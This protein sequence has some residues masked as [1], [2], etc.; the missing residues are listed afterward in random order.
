MEFEFQK[1]TQPC[2]QKIK[3]EVRN[4]EE[5]QE[6]RIPE[7]MPDVGTVLGAW[8][9]ALLRGKQWHSGEMQVTAGVMAWVMYTPE[10]GG[11]PQMLETWI[12]MQLRWDLPDTDRDGQIL[13][14]SV[15]RNVDARSV[16]ARKILVRAGLGVLAEAVVPGELPVYQPTDIPEDVQ[17]LTTRYPLELAAE[18]G[19]KPFSLEEILSLP[20]GSP[21]MEKPVYYCLQPRIG[22]TKVLAGKV[23]FRG[24]AQLHLLYMGQ[25]GGLYSVD[26]E[27]PFSQYGE[28][29]QDYDPDATAQVRCE[30][31]GLELSSGEEGQWNLKAGLTGQYM[32]YHCP[33]I[34]VVEDGYSLTREAIPNYTEMPVT[35]VLDRSGQTI[36]VQQTV[37]TDARRVIDLSMMADHGTV[38]NHDGSVEITVPGVC[39]MLYE[40]DQGQLRSMTAGWEEN[41]DLP[42]DTQSKVYPYI[43]LCGMPQAVVGADSVTLRG[44]LQIDAVTTSGGGM[45]MVSGL[46][47]GQE[48]VPDPDRPSLLLCRCGSRSLW[49]LAKQCKTTTDAICRANGL[50]EPPGANQ[51]LLIPI[52]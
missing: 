37:S 36:M 28:L 19:E 47:L 11:E 8:G 15:L 5:T 12:P 30:V 9:Q 33:V 2:L 7:D 27:M 42:A 43:S 22:E 29:E 51:V 16:S 35:A 46:E 31:T 38:R 1:T 52:A 34:P 21:P 32:I 23:V 24:A 45:T 10:G 25:D 14:H 17:L 39:Q 48:T 49:E 6:I 18:A 4:C 13:T 50:S 41:W 26:T 20:A 3:W 44:D 40:D